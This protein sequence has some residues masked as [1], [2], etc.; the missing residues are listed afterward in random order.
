MLVLSRQVGEVIQIGDDIFVKVV[1]IEADRVR[2]GIEAPRET[3]IDRTELVQH[4][5]DPKKP[6][7]VF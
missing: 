1:R 2:L 7:H 3:R 6:G 5:L 4:A